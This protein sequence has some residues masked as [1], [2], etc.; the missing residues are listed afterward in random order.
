MENYREV[1]VPDYLRLMKDYLNEQIDALS[2]QRGIFDL[3]KQRARLSDEEF[4]ILQIAYGDA[5]DYDPIV[6]LEYTILEPELR[7]RVANS[8]EELAALGS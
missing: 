4:G 6:R 7:R 1:G 5:D 2:Y 8:I 3:M